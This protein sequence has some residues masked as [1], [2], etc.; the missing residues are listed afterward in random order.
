MMEQ[1]RQLLRALF[2][3]CP[4][5]RVTTRQLMILADSSFIIDVLTET[6]LAGMVG[7]GPE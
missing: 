6:D 7:G 5:T 3:P 4:N 1:A 2:W